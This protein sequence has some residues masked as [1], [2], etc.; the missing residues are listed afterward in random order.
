MNF[1]NVGISTVKDSTAF[2]KIQF[3]SKIDHTSL[4]NLKSDFNNSFNKLSNLYSSDLDFNY[5][6]NYGMDRQHNYT[7]LAS[8]LPMFS[9][10]LDKNSV[11]K[12]YEYNFNNST[13]DSNS[14]NPFTI[15]R[16]TFYNTNVNNSDTINNLLYTY[17][18]LLPTK[19]SHIN[20]IDFETFLK[21]PNI[22]NFLS[23]E[24]DSK[25]FSNPLRFVLNNN[26]KRK[27][28]LNFEYL[29]SNINVNLKT[30]SLTENYNLNLY[31]TE[32]ILKFKDYKSSNLQF[33]G[34]ERTVRLLKNLNSDTYK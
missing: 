28:L 21:T 4:F 9:T 26:Q 19:L 29:L 20:T 15:N 32:N 3:F 1:D 13:R 27:L 16:T 24:N 34:S 25:Q 14:K 17:S 5:S 11:D 33:L 8:T 22:I 23:Y 10:N 30:P 2:K 31:N 18:K 7:S 12:F 6:A